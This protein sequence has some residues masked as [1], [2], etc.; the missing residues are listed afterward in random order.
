MLKHK[1]VKSVVALL[2]LSFV[3]VANSV[4]AKPKPNILLIMAEDMSSRVGAFGDTVAITPNLDRLARTSIRFPNTFT[5]AGVCAP[6]RAAHILGVHQISVGAQH[7][8]TRSYKRSTYRAVPPNH[9]KAYPELLRR[10]GYYTFSS[11]KLDYQ[12]SGIFASSGPFT[13]WDYAGPKPTWQGRAQGQPFFGFVSIKQTHEGQL[14]P[15]AVLRNNNNGDRSQVVNPDDVLLPPYYP[16]HP[17]VRADIAQHYN[18]IYTMDQVVGQLLRRLKKDGLA[19]NTIVI[20]TTDHGDGLPRGKRE[21]Y[22]SGIKVPLLVHWPKSLKPEG[23]DL[24]SI[25]NKLVSFVDIGP[26]ILTL[27]GIPIPDYMHGSAQLVANASPKRQYIYAS[28]DRLDDFNFYE[29]AVRD[30]QFK[31]IKN[32]NPKSPGAQPIIYRD[33]LASMQTLWQQLAAG[34]LNTSQRLWFEPT[35]AEALYDI[36]ADPHEVNNLVNS[37][38]H[39]DRLVQMRSALNSWRDSVGDFSETTELQ[40]AKQFWPNGEQPITQPPKISINQS[41]I[42][43]IAPAANHDS[44]GY[45]INGGAWMIYKAPVSVPKG[46]VL[47]AKAVRYGWAESTLVKVSG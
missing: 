3:L 14:F 37:A 36:Q 45:R 15:K 47:E 40:M 20:W 1:R 33:N 6:S 44:M 12:F 26:S 42:A 22:D 28:K 25:N 41:G 5:T 13:I 21:I 11:A 23:V 2:L 31:Y 7:M 10:H 4:A 29:R 18:N 9:M 46:G 17:A 19:D 16:D 43:T 34:K 8:R 35:P 32:F 27:A 39:R 30:N 24:G 38:K